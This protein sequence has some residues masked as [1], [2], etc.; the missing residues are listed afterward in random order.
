[1]CAGGGPG[2]LPLVSGG[3]GG[4]I[5]RCR[6]PGRRMRWPWCWPRGR[7]RGEDGAVP[8]P[9]T[10]TAER[11]RLARE[12]ARRR[13]AVTMLQISAATCTYAAS[14]LG[15]GTSPD[16]ARDTALFVAGELT[17]MAASLRRLTRMGLA[18]RRALA[19]QLAGLGWPT[20]QI[21]AQLGVSD[22]AVRYY[23]AGRV[24]PGRAGL[25]GRAVP[26]SPT[27]G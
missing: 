6:R 13:E 25:S 4:E 9:A 18:E 26:R 11:K 23:V 17:A 22:R 3:P 19:R 12:A 27:G 16:E 15:N 1:M 21:A 14:Q 10:V 20:R 7:G 2:T 5:A 24:C 8:E